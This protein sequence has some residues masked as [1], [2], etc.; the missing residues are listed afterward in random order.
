MLCRERRRHPGGGS[1]GHGAPSGRQAVGREARGQ[2]PGQGRGRGHVGGVVVPGTGPSGGCA[3]PSEGSPWGRLE[4][5]D[6]GGSQHP[7]SKERQETAV[8]MRKRK[9][10]VLA[11]AAGTGA[12]GR[13]GWRRRR[14]PGSQQPWPPSRPLHPPAFPGPRALNPM[15]PHT[16]S[17]FPPGPVP[18]GQR[19]KAGPRGVG[20]RR[21][22]W[23][24][25][26]LPWARVCEP[27]V[28]GT[29]PQPLP[30]LRFCVLNVETRVASTWRGREERETKTAKPGAFPPLLLPR[31][32][33]ECHS[34]HT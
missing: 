10:L 6:C 34:P 11:A 7:S 31:A 3:S 32:H 22:A 15:A 13:G 30:R 4:E 16:P 33:E 28:S 14:K 2:R 26:A 27:G 19:Q 1:G 23:G 8:G 20:C 17:P 12:A 9:R 24:H 21:E 18:A 29:V 5:G 25:L